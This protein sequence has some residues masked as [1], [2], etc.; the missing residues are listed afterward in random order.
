MTTYT[1]RAVR[2]GKWWAIEIEELDGVYSQALR[3]DQAEAMARDA[4]AAT[5]DVSPD[6]F[7]VTT[8]LL[9]R[10]AITGPA[11]HVPPPSSGAP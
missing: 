2:S 3:L 8:A 1:A 10:P 5:L 6:S 7:E 11:C 4:I 9:G